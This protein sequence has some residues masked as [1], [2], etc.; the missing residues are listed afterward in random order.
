MSTPQQFATSH[1]A[2]LFGVAPQWLAQA[3]GRVNL[4]GEHTDYNDGFVLPCAIDFFTAIAVSA[5]SDRLVRVVAAD[6]ADE[7]DVFSLDEPIVPHPDKLWSTYVRGGLLHL[8]QAG[9]QFGGLD[10]VISGNIPQGTGLSS[11]A[12]LL[13]AVGE[14]VKCA[15]QLALTPQAN[16]L[17]AQRAENQFVGV[18]C[19][20]MDQ[21]ISACGQTGHALMIDC[22][23]LELTP[24]SVPT[25]LTVM[26]INSRIRRGLVDGEYN[27]RRQQCEAAAAHFGVKALRDVTLAQLLEQREQLDPLLFRRARHIVTENARVE[28]A[29]VALAANDMP[30][31]ARLMA[32]SHDS[33]RDDFE[34]TV[35][36]IDQLV[37]IVK[38]V[39]GD[40]G[41]V[42]MTGGGFGGCVVALLPHALVAPVEQALAQQYRNAAGESAVVY[43]CVASS[44]AG[45]QA[46][47]D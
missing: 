35:P 31:L 5:R 19:G 21:L 13:V 12:S 39:V 8:Q 22:R 44:G 40:A 30:T 37:D 47:L 41:G 27:L 45:H 33:M 20:I 25:D 1:F 36:L 42:R 11:S 24:V 43:R 3:P 38:N 23:S 10:M 7:A 9:H 15:W 2:N 18:Q 46:M 26:I 14:A 6:Y 4:I 29:V 16:A 32:Q 17:N 28:Q 34:I